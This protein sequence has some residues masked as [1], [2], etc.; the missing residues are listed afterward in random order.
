MANIKKSSDNKDSK[1]A[2]IMI[3][4]RNQDTYEERFAIANGKRL[5]FEVPLS[6]S[7]KDILTLEKQKEP[8][9]A[10]NTMTVYDIMDKYGVPQDKA[11]SIL[12]AQNTHPDINGSSIKWRS[13]YVIQRV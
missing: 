2:R 1:P 8:F 13:K 5:P 10:N 9:K 6:L 11:I 7:E 3:V 4:P 12:E